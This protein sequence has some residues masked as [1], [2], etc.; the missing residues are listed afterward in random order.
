MDVVG[1]TPVEVEVDPPFRDMEGEFTEG[2]LVVFPAG[3]FLF[4]VALAELLDSRAEGHFLDCELLASRLGAAERYP[5]LREIGRFVTGLR[6]GAVDLAAIA[7]AVEANANV[8][9]TRGG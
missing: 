1:E 9:D 4:E 2:A 6:G 3:I 8:R 7:F 5:G